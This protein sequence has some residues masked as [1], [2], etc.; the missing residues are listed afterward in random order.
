MEQNNVETLEEVEVTEMKN[1]E[2]IET[3][4]EYE[5]LLIEESNRVAYEKA[6]NLVKIGCFTQKQENEVDFTNLEQITTTKKYKGLYSLYRDLNT[7]QLIFVCPLVENN[8]GDQEENKN[9][10][11]YA[12]DVLYVEVMD[13]E[14][15][16]MVLKA[17]KNTS[18]LI[19]ILT[20][21]TVI[22]YIVYAVF[23]LIAG[24][25]FFVDGV[26]NGFMNGLLYLSLYSGALIAGAIITLPL[27]VLLL[28][29]SK[30]Y[31]D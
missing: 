3:L 1:E 13:E 5:K 28:I 17:N 31:K 12:Y 23:S 24:C 4:K 25:I 30:Q 18:N 10:K 14:T 8:K 15:Y 22:S 7:M 9:M 19:P 2:Q 27:V 11:P 20:K 29:K 16:E 6:A 21:V 26:S